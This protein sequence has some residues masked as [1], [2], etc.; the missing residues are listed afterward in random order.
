VEFD[1]FRVMCRHLVLS[2]WRSLRH[3]FCFAQECVECTVQTR[4]LDNLNV[5][6]SV[7]NSPNIQYKNIVPVFGST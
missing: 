6:L 1:T 4:E 3:V 7:K 2:V 5:Y